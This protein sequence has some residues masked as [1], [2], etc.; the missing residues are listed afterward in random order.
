MSDQPPATRTSPDPRPRGWSWARFW[1]NGAVIA[2]VVGLGVWFAVEGVAPN[3]SPKNFGVVHEGTIYRSGVLTSAAM[4]DVIKAHGVR[5]IVD[6]GAHEPD[7]PGQQ[8]EEQVAAVMG[9]RYVRLPL[10]GDGTGDPNRYV[11]ALRVMTDPGAP[12]VL[13]HCSAGAER[14][15]GAV[16]LYR[17]IIEGAGFDEAYAECAQFRHD[18]ARNT[19]L[20]PYLERWRPEIERAFREGGTIEYDGPSPK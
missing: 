1:R 13:V 9:A 8:R 14:T 5:T 17:M 7:T 11:E 20:R 2:A 4:H 12:P 16:A 19:K 3:L 10:F 6:F 18:P 15:G